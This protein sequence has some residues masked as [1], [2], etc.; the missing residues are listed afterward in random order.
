MK[1]KTQFLVGMDVSHFQGQ[2]DWQKVKASGAQFAF[3][4]ATEG[5]TIVD[6]SFASNRKNAKAAGLICGFYHLFR[7]KDKALAQVDN[8]VNEIGAIEPGELPPVLDIEVPGDWKNITLAARQKLVLDWLVAVEA[9]LGVRPIGYI[10]GSDA[11][12]L[13]KNDP[14]LAKYLLWLANYTKASQPAVPRPWTAWTFW[15]HTPKGTISGVT[16]PVDLDHFQ[17][18]MAD[19]NKLTKQ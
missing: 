1:A 6:Q 17:G 9:R 14:A 13:L 5:V 16:G 15:Q 10:N 11:R 12:G 4:K 19:L 2:V 7:P 8:F 18:S 3:I